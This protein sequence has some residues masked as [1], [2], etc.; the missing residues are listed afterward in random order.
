MDSVIDN[1]NNQEDTDADADTD[2]DADADADATGARRDSAFIQMVR[3]RSYAQRH[4][5]AFENLGPTPSNPL[6]AS[7]VERV[8]R[9]STPA[10][11]TSA[12]GP[13]I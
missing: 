13:K 12:S 3:L 1:A 5:A 9:E 10:G 4:D 2:T 8:Q 6:L 11:S 7:R